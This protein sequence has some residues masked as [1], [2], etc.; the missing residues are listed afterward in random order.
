[1]NFA[2]FDQAHLLT[3]DARQTAAGTVRQFHYTHSV[4]S[5]KS[6]YVQFREAIVIWSLPANNN[7]AKFIL[8]W[9]GS[10]WELSRL[11]APD[12]HEKNLLTQAISKALGLLVELEHPDAV[13]AYADP[14]V[15]HLGGVYRA[16]SWMPHGQSEETRAYRGPDGAI[17]ARRAFHSGKNILIKREIEALGY[18]E[19][20]LPGKHRFVRPLSRRAKRTIFEPKQ[21]GSRSA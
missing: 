18:T 13:V 3:G 7:L 4:S 6:H 2:L 12:G 21:A 8:G 10:V 19:L 17:M 15:G 20:K 5:G 16:A 14:N 1:M 9:K 11:W